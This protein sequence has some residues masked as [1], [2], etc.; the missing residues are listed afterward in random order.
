V[1]YNYP[2]NDANVSCSPVY[3]AAPYIPPQYYPVYHEDCSYYYDYLEMPPGWVWKNV[4]G[5][6][7]YG[8]TRAAEGNY[9]VLN[10]LSDCGGRNGGG[11]E[12]NEQVSALVLFNDVTLSAGAGI[13]GYRIDYCGFGYNVITKSDRD[14]I[15]LQSYYDYEGGAN[16]VGFNTIS[17][18]GGEGV[19]NS[20]D[21][22]GY[23]EAIFNNTVKNSGELPFANEGNVDEVNSTGN[24]PAVADWSDVPV[25]EGHF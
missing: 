1:P 3:H 18:V 7:Y 15:W 22:S 11:I 12:L 25:R 4:A 21:R 5:Y 2:W 23:G 19:Q 14:G 6:Y 24:I 16:Q 13:L 9:V 10:D 8:Y 17:S 20:I